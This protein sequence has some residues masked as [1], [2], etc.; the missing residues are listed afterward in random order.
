MKQTK[1][2]VLIVALVML[3][4]SIGFAE[5]DRDLVKQVMRDNVSLMGAVSKAAKQEDYL[6]A[7]QALMKLAEGAISVKEFTPPKGSADEWEATWDAFIMAAFKGIGACGEEDEN[8]LND[9]IKALKKLNG[10]GH[11]EHR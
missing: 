4:S 2:I 5:Y 1:I 9:A 10:Q 3:V 11:K 6:A 7:G 8:G